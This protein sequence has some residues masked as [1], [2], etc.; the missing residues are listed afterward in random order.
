MQSKTE[1]MNNDNLAPSISSHLIQFH[2]QKQHSYCQDSYSPD[3]ASCDF[4]VQKML[5]TTLS[6]SQVNFQLLTLY[7]GG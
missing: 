3:T 7:T 6:Q 4:F 2:S 5:S 1:T